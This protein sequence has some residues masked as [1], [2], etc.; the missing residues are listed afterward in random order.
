MLNPKALGALAVAVSIVIV[1][2][3]NPEIVLAFMTLGY[4]A[5]R[6]RTLV[7]VNRN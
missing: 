6:N 1:A 3:S 4:L 2:I 5:G 7:I